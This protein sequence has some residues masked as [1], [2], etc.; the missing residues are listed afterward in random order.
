MKT[1]PPSSK[2]LRPASWAAFLIA[3]FA[4]SISAAADSPKVEVD[5]ATQ[6]GSLTWRTEPGRKYVVEEADTLDALAPISGSPLQAANLAERYAFTADTPAR[7][8]RVTPVDE[9][10]PE[11]L[12]QFPRDDGKAV[13]R[14]ADVTIVLGDESGVA[15]ASIT[16][17]V[18][19]SGAMTL[20]ATPGLG[21]D[22]RT[23]SFDRGGDT[24]WGAYGETVAA[25]LTVTDT[26]GNTLVHDWSFR[27]ELEDVVTADVF[28][29]GGAEAQRS[30]QRVDGP[31]AM[32]ARTAPGRGPM[33][34]SD[35]PEWTIDAVN[36]GSVVIA[37]T[38]AS[39]PAFQIDQYLANAT[40]DTAD[41]IFYRKITGISDDPGNKLLTL[42]TVDVGLAEMIDQGSISIDSAALLFDEAGDGTLVPARSFDFTY[43]LPEL[44]QNADGTVLFEN[45]NVTVSLPQAHWSFKPRL[46]VNLDIAGNGVEEFSAFAKGDFEAAIQPQIDVEGSLDDEFH[47]DTP[48][49]TG[50][51]HVW[52][53]WIGFVPVWVDIKFELNASAGYLLE[54]DATATTGISQTMDLGFGVIYRPGQSPETEWVSYANLPEPTIIPFTYTIHGHGNVWA[55][56]EPRLDILVVSLAGV[57][58]EVI[59]RLEV[60]GDFTLA[61]DVVT[62]AS[63]TTTL[64][65]DLNAGVSLP[66]APGIE[67][68]I[69]KF[70]YRLFEKSWGGVYMAE[71]PAGI[72]ITQQPQGRNVE[73]GSTLTLSVAA[74]APATIT[75]Q[76]YF[77]G[78]AI[79]G[80]EEA[81]LEI[82][83]I[84]PAFT[85][86][87]YVRLE[88]DGEV[89]DSDRTAVI[90]RQNTPGPSPEGFMLIPGGWFQMGQTGIATPV[91]EVY[92][93]GFYMGR[94]EV[95]KALWDEV[96][97]W[98]ANHGYTDLP[99]GGGK[100]AD[101]PVHTINWY[102]MVKWCNACS[103]KEGLVPC[104]T[105]GGSV[106]RTGSAAPDCNWSADGY[107]LPT[108]AEWEKAARGGLSG[109]NFPWGDTIN[110]SKANYRANG[111]AY[112]Y[113]TSPYTSYTFHPDWDD[114]GYPYTSPA[115]SFAPNGYGLYDMAGNVWEWCWDRW[116]SNYPSTAV[117]DPRGPASGSNRVVRGG[118]WSRSAFDCRAAYRDNSRPGYTRNYIG[119]RVARS[120]VP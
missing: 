52:I 81:D 40:P 75:Y 77:N 42:S 112:S 118:R 10:A 49:F 32:I 108:E 65:G 79:D 68:L 88:S 100:A 34:M 23:L 45:E 73:S 16:L 90:V 102:A 61:D 37:Y 39:A 38:G 59:P 55:Q 63:W 31:T 87:Y 98:G 57:Y 64:T 101:H 9:E 92:V 14:Y 99:T 84:T 51:K 111:S 82:R 20:A 72:L 97:A 2:S 8:F 86:E 26:K 70:H 117:T 69:P 22:G 89:L 33:P 28:V 24:A 76:W 19:T 7:F 15:P 94:T 13:G 6:E 114:G 115:G 30:G 119:F 58:G 12:D 5:P 60:D 25:T 62:E 80:E 74:A 3:S 103:E 78:G 11:I 53:G 27:L 83:D 93:S 56:L 29:F 50:T 4:L 47:T 54:A 1:P 48:L 95:T 104:Y 17:S 44:G 105:V 36:P 91:H 18:G 67:D 96:R 66:L 107:R 21:W 120:S 43:N 41:E 85:G 109:K 71:P 35:P 46:E 113:D 110:H 106:Y 116:G